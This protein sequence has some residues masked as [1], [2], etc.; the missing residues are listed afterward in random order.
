MATRHEGEGIVTGLV[1]V[2]RTGALHL[3]ICEQ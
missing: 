2:V 3:F 1:R